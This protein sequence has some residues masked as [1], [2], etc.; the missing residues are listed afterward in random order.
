LKRVIAFT[1]PCSIRT[2]RTRRIMGAPL[3]DAA[4]LP[5]HHA[6]RRCS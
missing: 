3:A 6:R 1:S 4:E 2:A 5:E